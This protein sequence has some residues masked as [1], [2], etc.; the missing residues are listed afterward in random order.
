MI[1]IRTTSFILFFILYFSNIVL[2][3]NITISKL[4]EDAGIHTDRRPISIGFYDSTANKTFV[5]WMG[6]YSD[7]IVKE[8]NHLTQTW[9]DDKIVGNSPFANSHNYPSLIQAPNG[10]LVI[11]YGCQN[12]VMRITSSPGPNSISGQWNDRDLVE[13]QGAT[14]PVPVVTEDSIIY[15]FYRVTMNRIY[16]D[17]LYPVDYRPL[18]Y[19][20]S[21][22]NGE[23]W[24]QPVRFVDHYP[25]VDNLC[26]IYGGKISYQAENDSVSERIHISWSISGGGPGNHQHNFYRRHVYYTYLDP[27][28]EHLYNINGNDLGRDIDDTEAEAFCKVVDTGTPPAGEQ[29]GH[30]VSVHYLD[31]GNPIIIYQH[32]GFKCAYRDGN[33]W[34]VSTIYYLSNEPRDI[35]KTGPREFRT[36]RTA[37]QSLYI[38]KT[39]DGGMNWH[40]ED[41]ITIQSE[42]KRCY[43]INNYHNDVKYLLNEFV[44]DGYNVG[45]AS[46]DVFIG[47]ISD[48]NYISEY[49]SGAKPSDFSLNQNYPNPFNPETVISYKLRVTGLVQLTIFNR[50][51]Q[52]V[53]ILVSEMQK[54]GIHK[55]TWNAAGLASGIYYCR[56]DVN[57]SF[58]QTRKLILMR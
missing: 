42:L 50:I 54:A 25:R 43:V 57:D 5:C 17:S 30:Q 1:M 44:D 8:F 15:C 6:S 22:D 40:L 41:K 14:Y 11:F 27:V 47:R 23:S 33:I 35:E 10:K 58:V 18:C 7:A 53:Q 37:G 56:L 31:D 51:G 28:N 34:D 2:S 52:E 21:D 3:G 38:F 12:S 16:P 55:L 26:E 20:K 9:S 49:T 24:S 4:S 36:Y 13:A 45:L 48:P 29:V 32:E 19:I 46:R 39:S